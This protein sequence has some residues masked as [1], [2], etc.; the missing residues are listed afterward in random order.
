M[1]GS[2][3]AEGAVVISRSFG[4]IQR[5]PLGLLLGSEP[6]RLDTDASL[7][8]WV[9]G[10]QRE[11]VEMVAQPGVSG[12]VLGKLEVGGSRLDLDDYGRGLPSSDVS[13]APRCVHDLGRLLDALSGPSSAPERRLGEGGVA[14]SQL[15]LRG[16]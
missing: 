13:P 4:T 14:G 8:A 12:V 11:P 1:R 5:P 3:P 6:W 15:G 2:N 7:E 10:R 16:A 9:R